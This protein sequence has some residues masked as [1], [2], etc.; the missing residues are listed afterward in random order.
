MGLVF[1]RDEFFCAGG[2]GSPVTE[3]LQLIVVSGYEG[4][5][6]ECPSCMSASR[7]ACLSPEPH[8][9]TGFTYRSKSPGEL[10][11]VSLLSC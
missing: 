2:D 10:T 3:M 1:D 4:E 8:C 5:R 6:G 7:L 9:T 11:D